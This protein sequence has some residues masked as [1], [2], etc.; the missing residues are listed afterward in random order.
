MIIGLN[1]LWIA[2]AVFCLIV[3]IWAM[4]VMRWFRREADIVRQLKRANEPR[5]DTPAETAI[6][7]RAEQLM[8][9]ERE[10]LKALGWP[11]EVEDEE[12][13][14]FE[15]LPGQEKTI[16]IAD[17]DPVVSLALTRR[18]ERLGYRVFRTTDA[19]HAL[20]GAKKLL[21]D[22]AILDFAMPPGNGLAVC[23]MMA[24]DEQCAKI[25]V[26]VHSIFHDEPVKR[27]CQKL[28]AHFV[29]KSP[30]SWREIKDLIDSLLGG[31]SLPEET[32]SPLPN[33]QPEPVTPQTTVAATEAETD[34]MVSTLAA[35]RRDARE[36]KQPEA[37]EPFEMVTP[38]EHKPINI[39]CIDD[40]PVLI[41]TITA[42]LKP[43]GIVVRG[44]GNGMQGYLDALADPPSLI[45]LDLK[46]PNGQGDYVISKLKDNPKTQNIPVVVVTIETTSGIQRRMTSLGAE[47]V[48]TKPIHW[49]ELFAK[50][51]R[52]I[53]LP[54][55][56]L[57]DYKLPEQMAVRET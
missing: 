38:W 22:L 57:N 27:R 54:D 23:E 42:R 2:A 13:P 56:L 21:P 24:C 25:P 47:S 17:D 36:Q 53:Q 52:C 26:I 28:N 5:D 7:G 19:T 15:P 18:L 35:S 51:G 10:S 44:A 29:E 50:M 41:H 8:H 46:M 48:V 45:L 12:R 20:F 43:Y 11:S 34:E 6:A 40:D 14:E 32:M 39:L 55:K 1:H 3:A 33:G 30:H 49:P 16:M 9:A 37:Q 4:Y 31:K